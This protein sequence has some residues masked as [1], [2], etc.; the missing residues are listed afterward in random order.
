MPD[1]HTIRKNNL[2][3]AFQAF[4]E[5]QLGAGIP[6]KG[7]DQSFAL[8]LRVSPAALSGHKSGKRPI[9]DRLTSQ[10]EDA[11]GRPK[12]WLSEE[13][14]PEGLTPAEQALIS[15]LLNAHRRTNAEG[16]RRLKALIRDF[17]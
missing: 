13:R 3:T 7:L 15:S 1:L 6:P 9:G 5:E 8:L 2:L 11:L 4:A 10:F 17:K 16:R 12:G 14:E